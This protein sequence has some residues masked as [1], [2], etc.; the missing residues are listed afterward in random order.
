MPDGS[1]YFYDSPVGVWTVV[2]PILKMGKIEAWVLV[3]ALNLDAGR[4]L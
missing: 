1:L 2:I 3:S 4:L